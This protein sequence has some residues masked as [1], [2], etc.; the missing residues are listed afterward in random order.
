MRFR[1]LLLG[2]TAEAQDTSKT[3][4]TVARLHPR[5]LI[6]VRSG[7][8]LK[9]LI[10]STLVA[11][12][13]ILSPETLILSLNMILTMTAASTLVMNTAITPRQGLDL[14]GTSLALSVTRYRT[15]CDLVIVGNFPT[16]GTFLI[17]VYLDES[18]PLWINTSV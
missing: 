16:I 2:W 12:T 15:C 6:I 11:E 17:L 13:H 9:D 4:V 8:V 14:V 1:I 5:R 7:L 10:I 18:C 3:Q